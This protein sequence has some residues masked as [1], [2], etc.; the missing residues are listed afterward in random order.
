VHIVRFC[1]LGAKGA[2]TFTA[3]CSADGVDGRRQLRRYL[4]KVA[5]ESAEGAEG[6][7]EGSA[8]PDLPV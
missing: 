6:S 5:V 4:S 8:L 7:A 1:M 3:A 2:K